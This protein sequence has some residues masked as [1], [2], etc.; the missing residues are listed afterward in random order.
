[1]PRS[2]VLYRGT[3]LAL[4]LGHRASLD[5]DFFSS[6]PLDHLALSRLPF[7]AGA[8][9]LQEES[10]TLTVSVQ[11]G[12]PVKISFFGTI[13]FGR[14]GEPEATSIVPIA[15][16]LDLAAT[17]IKVLLQRIEA[18]DYLDIA[19]LLRAR[20]PLATMLRAAR[21]L[22]G[23]AFNPLVAQKTLGFF[24]GGD[25]GS[26]DPSTR[27]LLARAALEDVELPPMP[28]SSERLA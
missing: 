8:H 22:F 7:L 26:L 16:L 28:R 2:F 10:E 1:V 3:A 27:E 5:F 15:S 9:V 14:V 11:R 20:V 4:R 24:E 25:L 23:T 13:G 18:K 6:E 12:D 17:K 21:T 19:A